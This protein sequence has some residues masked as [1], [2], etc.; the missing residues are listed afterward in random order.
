MKY[1]VV[2]LL[3]LSNGEEVA[4]VSLWFLSISQE[5]Y[6]GIRSPAPR[7]TLLYV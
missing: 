5:D 1:L 7:P 2:Q 3:S 6:G 4:F